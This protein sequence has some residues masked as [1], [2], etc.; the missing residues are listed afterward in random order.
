M[1]LHDAPEFN[2]R[3]AKEVITGLVRRGGQVNAGVC[4]VITDEKHADFG[5]LVYNVWFSVNPQYSVYDNHANF[6]VVE[7]KDGFVTLDG[8]FR[9]KGSV[10]GDTHVNRSFYLPSNRSRQGRQAWEGIDSFLALFR[11]IGQNRDKNIITQ[12][13]LQQTLTTLWWATDHAMKNVAWSPGDLEPLRKAWAEVEVLWTPP[14]PDDEPPITDEETMRLSIRPA[15]SSVVETVKTE[16]QII[17]TMSAGDIDVALIEWAKKN[18]GFAPPEGA[19]IRVELH[20]EG[21]DDHGTEGE[22][23][24]ARL[25]TEMTTV[26]K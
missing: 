13:V 3:V 2:T 16:H 1:T 21:C 20:E 5:R 8:T 6:R 9:L 23:A 24:Y 25:T 15:K 4:G 12:D 26:V 18:L 10:N 7:S 14:H 11:R 17:V 22:P 19:I